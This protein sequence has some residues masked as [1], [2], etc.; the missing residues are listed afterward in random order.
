MSTKPIKAIALRLALTAAA[1]SPWT[2]PSHT[3][4]HPSATSNCTSCSRKHAKQQRRSP[5]CR[6]HPPPTAPSFQT[7]PA[8]VSRSQVKEAWA[9]IT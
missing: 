8:T 4:T 1:L 3:A 6:P 7:W 9:S 5:T 2:R